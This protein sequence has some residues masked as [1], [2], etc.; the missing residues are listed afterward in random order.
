MKIVDFRPE[1]YKE[2]EDVYS[3]PGLSD[4]LFSQA[5]QMEAMSKL[6]PCWTF[7]TDDSRVIGCI[8]M[9]MLWQGVGQAWAVF[10]PL[11]KEY[12]IAVSRATKRLI[13]WAF[14]EYSLDRLQVIVLPEEEKN[15]EW[16]WFLGF[17]EEGIARRLVYGKD[18]LVM[19]IVREGWEDERSAYAVRN[20]HS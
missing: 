1:H 8:G 20:G 17:E 10:S 11:I 3:E 9:I 5:E 4:I 19:S 7:M 2:I 18:F 14:A 15:I 12:G 16:A 13:S 6:G